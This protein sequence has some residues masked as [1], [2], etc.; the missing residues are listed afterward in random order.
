MTNTDTEAE[1]LAEHTEEKQGNMYARRNKAIAHELAKHPFG[2]LIPQRQR[3]MLIFESH[4]MRPPIYEEMAPELDRL[5]GKVSAP[6]IDYSKPNLHPDELIAEGRAKVAQWHHTGRFNEIPTRYEFFKFAKVGFKNVVNSLVQKH[7]FT[8]KRTG[9]TAPKKGDEESIDRWRESV[10]F[11]SERPVSISLDD[12]ESGFQVGD[13]EI[14]THSDYPPELLEHVQLKM[15]FQERAVFQQLTEPNAETLELA[16]MDAYRG[17][18]PGQPLKIKIRPEHYAAGLDMPMDMY[19]D[20]LASMREKFQEAMSTYDSPDQI[21]KNAA[22]AQLAEIFGVQ[23]VHTFEPV[24]IRRM[25][26]IAAV[27]QNNKVTPEVEALLKMVG[28][29]VPQRRGGTLSCQGIL[30]DPR[31]RACSSCALY[32]QCRADAANVGL[33][34]QINIDKSKILGA[35]IVRQPTYSMEAQTEVTLPP[36]TDPRDEEIIQ[37]LQEN[38]RQG[39]HDGDIVYRHLDRNMSDRNRIVFAVDSRRVPLALRFCNPCATLKDELKMTGNG[40]YLPADATTKDAVEL[41]NAH[42]QHTMQ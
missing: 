7:V 21:K 5:M 38:F 12:E 36:V 4:R 24:V 29:I 25:F 40:W 13:N 39:I 15:T 28:A 26:T 23:V 3:F 34:G 9:I 11:A 19:N 32:N 37:F 8:R 2:A 16:K 27:L 42:A 20:K 31:T 33:D 30:P 18:K 35:K 22:T 41:I 17:H 10:G 14:A 6:Y 1:T